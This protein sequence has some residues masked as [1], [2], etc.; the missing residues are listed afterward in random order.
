MGRIWLSVG[1]QLFFCKQNT[2]FWQTIR[3]FRG[4]RSSV[5]YAIKDSAGNIL[6]NENEVVSRWIKYFEDLWNP[7]KASTHGTQEVIHLGKKKVFVAAEMTTAIIEI[8]LENCW[9]T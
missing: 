5:T 2:V 4:K 8:N 6:I 9:W 3:R 7:I 1:F